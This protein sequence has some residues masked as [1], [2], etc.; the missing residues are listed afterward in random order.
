MELGGVSRASAVTTSSNV[1]NQQSAQTGVG[2]AAP[3]LSPQKTVQAA[4][5]AE[6][7]DVRISDDAAT[8]ARRLEFMRQ[9]IAR[10]V[11]VDPDTR[12]LVFQAVRQRTGEVVQ[13]TPTDVSLKLRA[14]LAA[15]GILQRGPARQPDAEAEQGAA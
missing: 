3:E 15:S 7:V 14:Y 10:R 13:Q 11:E 6:A 12:Q 2:S 8:S 4:A 9:I 1:V 5:G